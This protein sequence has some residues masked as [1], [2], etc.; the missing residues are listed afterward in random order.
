M[1][2]RIMS[3]NIQQLPE[4]LSCGPPQPNSLERIAAALERIADELEKNL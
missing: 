2:V 4:V 3:A 1:L